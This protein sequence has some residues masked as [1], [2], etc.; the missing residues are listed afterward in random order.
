MTDW[1]QSYQTG[2]IFWNRGE[3]SLPLVQW[4]ERHGLSGRVLVPGC[5]LGHEVAWLRSRGVDAV[6]LDIAPTALVMAAQHYPELPAQAWVC[7]D[8]FN[9]PVEMQ[10]AF[11]AVVEHTCLSGLPPQLREDYVRGVLSA[12]K[13]SGL[14]VGVWFINP[15]R[16]PGDEG[17]PFTLP[18]ETLDTMFA[19]RAE[20]LEDYV[21]QVAFPGR[22]GRERM[23]VL[24]KL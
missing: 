17:P 1:E 23:R 20:V 12:I 14:I 7:A 2:Q 6:G 21:P 18:V 9:L 16:D 10:G 19:G 22:E 15:A 8:L 3:A 4:V 13:P 5:G 11:D 24:R